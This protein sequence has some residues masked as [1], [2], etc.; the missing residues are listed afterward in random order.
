MWMSVIVIPRIS[1]RRI[2]RHN[3]GTYFL[4]TNS[5]KSNALFNSSSQNAIQ[6]ETPT[7][8]TVCETYPNELLVYSIILLNI[9]PLVASSL[10]LDN[11]FPIAL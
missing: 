1:D 10:S 9:V 3:L 6:Y 2:F 11:D 5:Q 7:Y 4:I 8:I